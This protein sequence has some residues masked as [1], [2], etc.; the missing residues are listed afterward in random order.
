MQP[1]LDSFIRA[2]HV[3]KPSGTNKL[4][5]SFIDVWSRI[6]VCPEKKPESV[7]ARRGRAFVEE[8]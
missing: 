7:A 8:N 5:V 4:R 2:L 3:S 1:R 6:C